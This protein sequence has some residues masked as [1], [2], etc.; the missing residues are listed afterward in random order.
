MVR[1]PNRK[2]KNE[3]YPSASALLQVG[4]VFYDEEVVLLLHDW[5]HRSAQ[6]TID[7]FQ[8][9]RS[10]ANEVSASGEC[11]HPFVVLTT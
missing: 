8:S 1:T 10:L 3:L 6:E 11:E 7:W 9:I 5:Y 2:R 4:S